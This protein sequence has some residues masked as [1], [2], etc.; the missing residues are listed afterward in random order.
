MEETKK[1][2]KL[3]LSQTI[4]KGTIT[5][6]VADLSQ[7]RLT[8]KPEEGI[9]M[10]VPKSKLVIGDTILEDR[11]PPEEEKVI[12]K[13]DA[14][15]MNNREIFTSFI[16]NLL[17]PYKEVEM[18]E[19][20]KFSCDNKGDSGSAYSLMKQQQIVRDYMNLYTPYRGLLL[21]F[22]LTLSGTTN[23]NPCCFIISLR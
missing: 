8:K 4:S 20:N 1:K 10:E 5:G 9:I 22:G 13:S 16:N 15:Y 6:S 7:E 23:S 17:K 12:I 18:S 11:L 14:Y 3:K 21:Y 2:K 19:Q